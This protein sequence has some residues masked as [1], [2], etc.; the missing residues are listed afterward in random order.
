MTGVYLLRDDGGT[1]IY[2][3]KAV[4]I[5][6][7]V[8][9]HFNP[10]G[11][12]RKATA[13]LEKARA[14]EYILTENE[15]EA[16]ILEN[17]LINKHQPRYNIIFKDDKS[18]PWIKVTM[19]ENYPSVSITRELE[20]DGSKYYGPYV[21]V[22]ATRDT[23]KFI[24][25]YFPVRSCG[26]KIPG[27][28]KVR[29]CL[30][31]QI[32]R[33]MAPCAFEIDRDAYRS[34]VRN[35][36][37]FLEG[38]QGEL[39]NNLRREMLEA[40]ERQ[41]YERAAELRDIIR[42]LERTIGNRQNVAAPSCRDYDVVV[43]LKE[44]ARACVQ[45]FFI[46]SGKLIGEEHFINEATGAASPGGII[47][48]FIK[49][50]YGTRLGIPPELH[51]QTAFEDMDAITKLLSEKTG[52]KVTVK[53]P[54]RKDIIR[55]A[56]R[57][58]ESHLKP[59]NLG[60]MEFSALKS[61]RKELHLPRLP[62]L[63]EAMDISTGGGSESVGVVV[64]FE[65]GKPFK[66]GY[67]R[68][69]IKHVEGQDDLAMLREVAMRRYRRLMDERKSL[70]DLVIVDGGKGQLESVL[71]GMNSVAA[72]NVP[73][74]SI[75]KKFEQIYMPDNGE[76]LK[77]PRRSEALKL[78]QRA[79]DEAHRFAIGYHRKLRGKRM[80]ETA[81]MEIRGI[82]RARANRLL[83]RFGSVDGVKSA[84]AQEIA[85][86]KGFNKKIAENIVKWAK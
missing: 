79:R 40:S 70:P 51:I 38:K 82:G 77:L 34:I 73:V 27:E 61:L 52:S 17:T 1:I 66:N 71:D 2:V 19:K 67:R 58:A 9:S 80:K 48:A 14:V 33:C 22:D 28:V 78:I 53:V 59:K 32:K 23:V 60:E 10:S 55:M 47:A 45:L 20:E 83:L 39:V 36:C 81:L 43:C 11:K 84:S 15:I 50:F 76:P 86:V 63:I 49:Q 85:T 69:R 64:T 35:L 46:R 4:N 5:R 62:V 57:N 30:D 24:R 41:N 75:A 18:R 31:Y 54:K 12:G 21:D 6:S 68:F 29:P 7:R 3:G 8:R 26:R 74:V 56:V 13:M 25:R 44:C 16:L 65:N 42:R 72:N 37:L